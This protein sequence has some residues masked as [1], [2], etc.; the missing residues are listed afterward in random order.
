MNVDTT[1]TCDLCYVETEIEWRTRLELME[2][3]NLLHHWFR[4]RSCTVETYRIRR[5]SR[6]LRRQGTKRE[7]ERYEYS[8]IVDYLR[9]N[10]LDLENDASDASEQCFSVIKT[11]NC[12]HMLFYPRRPNAYL[13]DDVSKPIGTGIEADNRYPQLFLFKRSLEI[14][15]AYIAADTF[16]DVEFVEME[17]SDNNLGGAI[18]RKICRPIICRPTKK[19]GSTIEIRLA[20]Y[21]IL[22]EYQQIRFELGIEHEFVDATERSLYVSPYE[23]Q[24]SKFIS[25]DRPDVNRP[26]A[27]CESSYVQRVSNLVIPE[28][29]DAMSFVVRAITT[30]S[31]DYAE[32]TMI[33]MNVD[34]TASDSG[35]PCNGKKI[36]TSGGSDPLDWDEET[37]MERTRTAGSSN[38]PHDDDDKNE[39]DLTEVA[40]MTTT[41]TKTTMT[42]RTTTTTAVAMDEDEEEDEMG[43]MNDE[44]KES[45]VT[46]TTIGVVGRRRPPLSP[47]I[48]PV[49]GRSSSTTAEDQRRSALIQEFRRTAVQ[50]ATQNFNTKLV[51]FSTDSA[52]TGTLELFLDYVRNRLLPRWKHGEML[53]RR[54]IDG[55]RLYATYD[56]KGL[57]YGDDG[58]VIDVKKLLN[59]DSGDEKERERSS[60]S[61]FSTNFVYQFERCRRL[62]RRPTT[63]NE[64]AADNDDDEMDRDDEMAR[65]DTCYVLTE[66]VAV[67]NNYVSQL[68]GLTQS[69]GPS[70][71]PYSYTP[72]Q[73]WPYGLEGV[74]LSDHDTRSILRFW[75]CS[76]CVSNNGSKMVRDVVRRLRCRTTNDCDNDDTNDRPVETS[77]LEKKVEKKKVGKE[78]DEFLQIDVESEDA[79]DDDEDNSFEHENEQDKVPEELPCVACLVAERRGIRNTARNAIGGGTN[80]TTKSGSNEFVNLTVDDSLMFLDRFENELP[81]LSYEIPSS[82]VSRTVEHRRRRRLL[83]N[84]QLY[85]R[86]ITVSTLMDEFRTFYRST[87]LRLTDILFLNDRFEECK[88]MLYHHFPRTEANARENEYTRKKRIV[89]FDSKLDSL[90]PV[91]GFLLY[92]ATDKRRRLNGGKP[93]ACRKERRDGRSAEYDNCTT[94]ARSTCAYDSSDYYEH[95]IWQSSVSVKFKPYQTIELLLYISSAF[96]DSD[97][98]D[99][100]GRNYT[101]TSDKK[102]H[103][104][105]CTRATIQE[106]QTETRSRTYL[107]TH[108]VSSLRV[109]L[110]ALE[111]KRLDGIQVALYA[112]PRIA[113]FDKRVYEFLCYDERTFFLIR[114]RKDKVLPDTETKVNSIVFQRK[115]LTDALNEFSGSRSDRRSY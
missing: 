82:G 79:M 100:D 1:I 86:S 51:S 24:V 61:L 73:Q 46:D 25:T 101:K 106:Q 32:N 16:E 90:V 89:D 69:F 113:L 98:D 105:F 28:I 55:K 72:E 34:W 43:E 41:T 2:V 115:R 104:H 68:N 85:P 102:Y 50:Q 40:S 27:S 47:K 84:T 63:A 36:T 7:Y 54:K 65:V 97:D 37:A 62:R 17:K 49:E 71:V 60:S 58:D 109:Q 87:I 18:V 80:S 107:F 10:G 31:F 95:S 53:I 19:N 8:T 57:L 52:E 6:F 35:V 15:D 81:P 14:N 9:L 111:W 112:D 64:N 22:D 70:T 29:L 5:H 66:V 91:D 30:R 26:S 93:A 13:L 74:G 75:G 78:D 94:T 67:R 83:V 77:E 76:S 56:G 48:P 20:M 21:S 39:V 4:G 103:L 92:L 3:Q 59:N 96:V 108:Y 110:C 33:Q 38:G 23:F 114:A 11:T 12:S 45:S 99:Q 42:S 44:N 88:R